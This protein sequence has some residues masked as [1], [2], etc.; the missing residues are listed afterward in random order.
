MRLR[1]PV[2]E[3]IGMH[4]ERCIQCG[5]TRDEHGVGVTVVHAV[6]RH[7]ADARGAVHGVVPGEEGLAVGARILDAA[8]ARREVRAIFHRLELGLRVRVVV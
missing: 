1:V 3:P 6:R 2:L 8:K 5:L 4:K 7:V